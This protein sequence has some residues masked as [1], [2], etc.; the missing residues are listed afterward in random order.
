MQ[1]SR[2]CG[3]LAVSGIPGV[4]AAHWVAYVIAI[5]DAS[6][7]AHRL[8]ATGHGYWSIAGGVACIAALVLIAASGFRGRALA[9][10][11][12]TASSTRGRLWPLGLVA[13]QLSL[14]SLMEIGE[15]V[16]TG[17]APAAIVR[18]PVFLI[19]LT[20]QVLAAL[21]VLSVMR[22]IERG[23]ELL[24]GALHRHVPH[25]HVEAPV[26]AD[27]C[28]VVS[29]WMGGKPGARGPPSSAFC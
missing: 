27:E 10:G 7:R 18:D 8:A 6:Q 25:G 9:L 22:A 28:G 24:V 4:V 14:F 26:W 21:L 17:S 11:P 12:V 2:S 23:V 29:S 13:W 1:R 3:L 15:R 16:G 20:I 19:G 5:P